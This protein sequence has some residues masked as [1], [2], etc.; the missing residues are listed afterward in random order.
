MFARILPILAAVLALTG[1]LALQ[2]W[3]AANVPPQ[4][5]PAVQLTDMDNRPQRLDAWPGK[6]VLL[7]F[8]ASWCE[9]C[10]EEI[11]AL[12]RLQRQYGDK[13]LQIIGVAIDDADPVR[14]FQASLPM[15]YPVLL[16]Q[17]QGIALMEQLGNRFG[18]LPYTVIFDR[19]GHLAQ[20]HPGAITQQEAEAAL[21]PFLNNGSKVF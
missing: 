11:P 5:L 20:R 10:R 4:T 3:L 12:N 9:P 1:G 15:N 14:Q 2:H 13:G 17:D 16:A 6:V 21:A 7:N 18:V 8:W 19:Q